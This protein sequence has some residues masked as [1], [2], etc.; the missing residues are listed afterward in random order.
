[1]ASLFSRII[2]GEIPAHIV[3]ED[4]LTLAFMD[5]HPIQ[6]G[7]VLVVSKKEV[8]SFEQLEHDD[9]HA[10]METVQKVAKQIKKVLKPVRVGVIIEGFEVPHAH[11][12][13]F[14]INNETEL[15]QFPN[16]ESEPNHQELAEMA[17]RIK[18]SNESDN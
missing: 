1:M 6:K 7:H 18:I 11:V 8:E 9:Y 17:E 2:S 13:V 5:I 10:V 14:P 4:E 12:K 16:M 3:Y 15:R